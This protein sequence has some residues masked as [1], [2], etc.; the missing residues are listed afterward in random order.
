[1]TKLSC[2]QKRGDTSQLHVWFDTAKGE[3]TT[4]M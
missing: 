2:L 3:P 4:G 1:M